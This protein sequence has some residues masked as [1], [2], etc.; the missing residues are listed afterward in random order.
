MSQTHLHDLNALAKDLQA[1]QPPRLSPELAAMAEAALASQ[2]IEEDRYNALSPRAQRLARRVW[3][4]KLAADAF[5]PPAAPQ[6][7]R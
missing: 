1:G 4:K 3:A 7:T 2:K 5:P 6:D